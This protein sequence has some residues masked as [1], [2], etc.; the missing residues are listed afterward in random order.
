MPKGLGK[1]SREGR[2]GAVVMTAHDINLASTLLD[3]T[4][5]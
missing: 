4:S 3:R 5:E 1:I 2:H